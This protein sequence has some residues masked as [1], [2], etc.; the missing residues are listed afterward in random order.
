M[1]N[2]SFTLCFL[3]YMLIYSPIALS[4]LNYLVRGR[5]AVA[6]LSKPR[7]KPSFLGSKWAEI[8][9]IYNFIYAECRKFDKNPQRNVVVTRFRR[10]KFRRHFGDIWRLGFYMYCII[11]I[12]M[13]I[14]YIKHK[15]EVLKWQEKIRCNLSIQTKRIPKDVMKIIKSPRSRR[16]NCD[17]MMHKVYMTRGS[18]TKTG[19][20]IELEVTVGDLSAT[21]NY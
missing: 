18:G 4:I 12:M 14:I 11:D 13:L 6:R 5:A 17:S 19:N 9:I 21:P 3:F 7:V 20:T 1:R 10:A 8:G 2:D 15:K 16:K